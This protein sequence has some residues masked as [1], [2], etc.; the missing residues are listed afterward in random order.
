MPSSRA[1]T[2]FATLKDGRLLL[3]GGEVAGVTSNDLVLFDP[4]SLTFQVAQ[5]R[6]SSPRRD[7][8][9]AVLKD[10]R[11]LIGGGFDGEGFIDSIDRFD[12]A[13]GIISSAGRLSV[14]RSGLSATTLL[15]GR[16]VFIGGGDS[17]TEYGVVEIYDPKTGAIR[18]DQAVMAQPRRGHAALRVPNNNTV[19]LIGGKA[20]GQSISENEAYVPWRHRFQASGTLDAGRTAATVLS[21]NKRGETLVA[22]GTGAARPMSTASVACVPTVQTDQADYAGDDRDH[23]RIVLAARRNRADHVDRG[24]R[25]L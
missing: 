1:G 16:V 6:L 17:K 20:V 12:P 23:Y 7:H 14:A 25:R 9:M 5:A 8:A 18:L 13:T 4:A 19:L 22:G 2:A 24:A 10:G 3:A 11:V 21:L 15:D